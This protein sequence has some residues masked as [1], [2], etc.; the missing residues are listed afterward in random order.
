MAATY[1]D[2]Q[3]LPLPGAWTVVSHSC[4]P[5]ATPGLL[6]PFQVQHLPSPMFLFALLEVAYFVVY[7][8]I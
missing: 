1:G 5:I 8:H 4:H 3:H 2:L 6:S 7:R